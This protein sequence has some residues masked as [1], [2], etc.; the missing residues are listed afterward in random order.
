MTP[1]RTRP[2]VVEDEPPPSSSVESTQPT[3]ASPTEARP[4]ATD[5]DATLL[6]PEGYQMRITGPLPPDPE[7]TLNTVDANPG[8]TLVIAVPSSTVLTVTNMTEGKNYSQNFGLWYLSPLYPIDSPVCALPDSYEY[9]GS[10]GEGAGYCWAQ[11]SQGNSAVR[12]DYFGSFGLWDGLKPE[13]SVE[14]E[15]VWSAAEESSPVKYASWEVPEAEAAA[16]AAAASTPAGWALST[17]N[18]SNW[19]RAADS[20]APAAWAGYGGGDFLWVTPGL[21]PKGG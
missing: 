15:L 1:A 3:Q 11:M 17:P 10:G 18:T 8:M 7:F 2:V 14:D 16:L 21:E 20:S 9:T 12:L 5:I 6:T 19:D 13:D 4:A